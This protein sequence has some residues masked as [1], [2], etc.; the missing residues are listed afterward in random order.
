MRAGHRTAYSSMYNNRCFTNSCR[1]NKLPYKIHSWITKKREV[2]GPS[3]VWGGLKSHSS[4]KPV[5]ISKKPSTY[6]HPLPRAIPSLF[7]LH[8]CMAQSMLDE[9]C[10]WH[11]HWEVTHCSCLLSLWERDGKSDFAL[12]RRG[13]LNMSS[14]MVIRT[15]SECLSNDNKSMLCFLNEWNW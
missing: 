3:C 11:G 14:W 13:P 5:G 2:M 6:V 4:I 12:L 9:P 10:W 15:S 7:R 8:D 1:R